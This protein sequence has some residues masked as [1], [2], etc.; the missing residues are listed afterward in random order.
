M[1]VTSFEIHRSTKKLYQ[2][3]SQPLFMIL[4]VSATQPKRNSGNSVRICHCIQ[5]G[6][7]EKSFESH[8][9]GT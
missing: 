4:Q 7:N 9:D 2:R 5:M 8:E 6:K 1:V 3:S